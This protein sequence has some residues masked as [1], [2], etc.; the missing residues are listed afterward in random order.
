[1][2]KEKP[3]NIQQKEICISVSY[4]R[5]C[6]TRKIVAFILGCLSLI[7]TVY[8]PSPHKKKKKMKETHLEC[9]ESGSH[10]AIASLEAAHQVQH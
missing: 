6:L 5:F 3:V 10:Q 4:F 1:M 2:S 8:M 9:L 7:D